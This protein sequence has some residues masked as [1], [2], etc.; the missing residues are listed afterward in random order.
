MKTVSIPPQ[1]AE[2][3]ALLEQARQEDILVRTA[4]GTQ[5]MVTAVDDFDEEIVRT[6]QCEAN[7]AARR[8][9]R[10]DED[11]S[12]GRGQAPLDPADSTAQGR[13]CPAGKAGLTPGD[14]LASVDD[15]P[16]VGDEI[17]YWAPDAVELGAQVSPCGGR[18]CPAHLAP[19]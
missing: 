5:Y 16:D 3:N 13:L 2:V 14:L 4:D 6:E 18:K 19:Q 7:G 10:P 12:A 8:S 9:G 17:G 15:V 1:A 11:H